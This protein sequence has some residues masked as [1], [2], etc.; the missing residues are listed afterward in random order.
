MS[1]LRPI[2]SFARDFGE[3]AVKPV[4]ARGNRGT[5]VVRR[6]IRGAVPY[7][8]S[9]E[10]HMD[11]DTFRRDHLEAMAVPAIVME[12]LLRRPTT[13][14]SWH[15]TAACCARCRAGASILPAYRTPAAY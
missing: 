14:M 13:S 5:V 15:R 1:C 12:R 8:G 7:M 10:L 9:R 6:D 4:T 2:D 3:F 11:L